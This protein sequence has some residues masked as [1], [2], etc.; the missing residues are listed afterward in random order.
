MCHFW[1]DPYGDWMT[2]GHGVTVS[3]VDL[4]TPERVPEI[5][6]VVLAET[7]L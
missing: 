3:M 1:I 6:T 7:F 2:P 4:V 5:V